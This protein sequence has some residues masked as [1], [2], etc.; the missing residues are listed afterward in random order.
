MFYYSKS[1]SGFYCDEVHGQNIPVDAVEISNTE[2]NDFYNALNSGK[3][4]DF[5]VN[6]KLCVVDVS[7]EIT[8]EENSA[9]ASQKL[10]MT[11][12]AVNA[13][14]TDSTLSVFLANKD[15]YIQYRL[16]L[17]ALIANKVS[18][19]VEWPDSPKAVWS[20]QE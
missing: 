2:Y 4:I 8:S 3:G 11:D 13:D 15:E 20:V 19:Q 18:G 9:I 14:V 17:R 7:R 10:A 1:T 16:F 5:D 6:G 12:W